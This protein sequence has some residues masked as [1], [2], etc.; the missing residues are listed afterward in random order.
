MVST[1]LGAWLLRGGRRTP[2]AAGGADLTSQSGGRGVG[3]AS[4]GRGRG[5]GG[6]SFL[7]RRLWLGLRV[8]LTAFGS[9]FGRVSEIFELSFI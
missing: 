4:C 5:P 2:G 3:G 7:L 8:P 1:L 9:A 6:A